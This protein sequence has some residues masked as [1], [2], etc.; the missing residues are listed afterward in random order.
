[1]QKH[2]AWTKIILGFILCMI[3]R[4]LPVRP[5][6]VEPLLATQMPFA[7][8]YGS[9]IAFMFAFMSIVFFDLIVGKIGPWTLIV[10]V[11]YGVLGIWSVYF[12]KTREMKRVNYVKF[13]IIATLFFDAVTGLTIGPLL[14]NQ[15]FMQAL[16]GQI[17]FTI[18]HLAGNVVF[19][20]FLS[21]LIY[22]YLSTN[23]SLDVYL[24]RV[25]FSNSKI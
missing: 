4:L 23:K 18:L 10:G 7:K 9:Y 20:F 24:G 25:I 22:T 8:A 19:A 6:N 13:A 21:P 15:T 12:F 2:I 14:F 5:P 3:F 1:M 11:V 16:I 17:P